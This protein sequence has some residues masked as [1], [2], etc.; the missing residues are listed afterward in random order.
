MSRILIVDDDM[1]TLKSLRRL[2]SH[3]PCCV[4]AKI[5]VLSV[6]I[7]NDPHAALEKA[8]HIPYDLVLCDYRM[9]QMSGIALLREIRK[10]QPTAACLI[11]SGYP[12]LNG[13]IAAINEI[14]I[15]RFIPKP[16]NDYELVTSVAQVLANRDLHLELTDPA[17]KMDTSSLGE[18]SPEERERKR[19]EAEQ[20]GITKVNWGPDGSVI[21]DP[22]N[23]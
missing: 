8:R 3:A 15:Q 19:L 17:R 4:G 12:D 1:N 2:L 9:P 14:G 18:N 13:L 16:W 5:Y 7:C 20:P 6:D 10:L 21:L 22:D 23:S 11:L